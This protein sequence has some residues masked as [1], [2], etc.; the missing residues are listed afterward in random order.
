QYR[1]QTLEAAVEMFGKAI[2]I[3]AGFARA[4]AGLASCYSS[5]YTNWGVRGDTLAQAD[6]AS[7][8]ALEL[9]PE[10][11]ES[12]TARGVTLTIP[13]RQGGVGGRVPPGAEGGGGVFAAVPRR[14]PRPVPG[15][16]GVVPARRPRTGAGVG[17]AGAGGRSGRGHD[18]VQRRLRVLAGGPDRGGHR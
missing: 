14:R 17:A 3:D 7:Q 15:G 10:S 16:D 12:H 2:E 4:Y 9:D 18:A 1:R 13:G 8:K 5:L 6:A 11:A